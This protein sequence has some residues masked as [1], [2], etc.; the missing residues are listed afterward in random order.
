MSSIEYDVY[1]STGG[2]SN[3]GGGSDVWVTHWIKEIAPKLDKP[4]RLLIDRNKLTS[5]VDVNI[6]VIL[7]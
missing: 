2:V 4:F 6:Q 5:D 7:Q 1:Y 3:I